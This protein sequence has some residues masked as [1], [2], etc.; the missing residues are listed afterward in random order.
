MDNMKSFFRAAF[1]VFICLAMTTLALADEIPGFIFSKE[2]T[3]E[4]ASRLPVTGELTPPFWTPRVE[5]VRALEK[6]LPEFIRKNIPKNRKPIGTL[7]KYK[8]QYLGITRNGKMQ[9][10]IN[11]FCEQYWSRGKDWQ[12]RFVFVLDGG[13]CYFQILFDPTTNE[14]TNFLINGEG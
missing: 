12:S 14:F 8:R 5:Q 7:S 3:E 13:N 6:L 2:R 1:V 10:Y 11:G 9:I 4:F